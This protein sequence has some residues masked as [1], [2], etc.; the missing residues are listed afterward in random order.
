MTTARDDY[1]VEELSRAS[2]TPVRVGAGIRR[3]YSAGSPIRRVATGSDP[4]RVWRRGAACSVPA[5]TL[6]FTCEGGRIVADQG[7]CVFAREHGRRIDSF[8]TFTAA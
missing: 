6:G 8:D 3:S 7:V 4:C 2:T 5:V 1:S